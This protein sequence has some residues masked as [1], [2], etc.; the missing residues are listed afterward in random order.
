LTP[1]IG[2]I[3][4]MASPAAARIGESAV[5]VG[6]GAEAAT[7]AIPWATPAMPPMRATGADGSF[8]A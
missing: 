5:G 6:S 4:T 3:H 2:R 7:Q 8:G 1:A